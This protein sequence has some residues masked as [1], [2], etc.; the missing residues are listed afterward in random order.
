MQAVTAN[1]EPALQ[2]IQ[3]RALARAVRSLNDDQCAGIRPAGYRTSGLRQSRF[4][5]VWARRFL[6][7]VR[8]FHRSCRHKGQRRLTLSRICYNSITTQRDQSP[9]SAEG[10]PEPRRYVTR[11]AKAQIASKNGDLK[12]Q[13]LLRVLPEVA[14]QQPQ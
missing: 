3:L 10:H 5:G 7:C 6:C 12:M 1:F 14:D 9:Q 13:K 2:Q 4:G 8:I 11:E